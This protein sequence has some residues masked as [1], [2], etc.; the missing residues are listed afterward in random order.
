MPALFLLLLWPLLAY[1]QFSFEPIRLDDSLSQSY[2][3]PLIE[4]SGNGSLLCAWTEEGSYEVRGTYGHRITAQGNLTG[5]GIVYDE[6]EP[7]QWE[8]SPKLS[9]VHPTGSGEIR[10]FYDT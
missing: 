1:A 8:C 6:A 3:H 4:Q 5:D 9:I 2:Y 7:W 10:L